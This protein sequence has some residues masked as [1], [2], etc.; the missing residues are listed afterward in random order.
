LSF[1]IRSKDLLARTG[2]LETKSGVF[3]TPHMFP[4]VDPNR[5]HLTRAVLKGVDAGA[6]MTNAYLLRR[7]QTRPVKIELHDYLGFD[8]T[9]ATDSGAYQ[10]LEFGE[11]AVTPKEI[12]RYQEE[13]NS[14]IAVILDVPTGFRTS[15][16]RAR[17][18]VDETIR[19]ADEA[20]A[21][22]TRKDILWVGPIQGGVHL[23][24]VERSATEMGK[25]D[26]AIY[27]LGSPTELMETQHFDILVDMI[28]AAKKSLPISKPFHLFGAG[29]PATFPF[30]VALGC[31]LFD[32]AAYALYAKQDKYFTPEGTLKLEEMEELPCNCTTCRENT[33]NSIRE[34]PL[35]EKELLIARHNLHVCMSELRK[36]REMIRAGRLWEMLEIR[37]HAHPAFMRCFERISYHADLLEQY[38]PAVKLHGI[39]YYGR[40]TDSRPEIQRYSTKLKSAGEQG[41]RWLVLLPSGWRRP[42]H[43]DPAVDPIVRELREI[44][45]V[46]IVFY[47]LAFGPV[48][49]ELDEAYPIPHTDIYDAG[50]SEEYTRSATKV[51]EYV[52]KM[53]PRHI[54]LVFGTGPLGKQIETK[55]RD[56]K[57]SGRMKIG[58]LKEIIGL[59]AMKSQPRKRLGIHSL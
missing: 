30:F 14:D 3:Q 21:S 26:F 58:T 18:T 56:N 10:I 16:Q 45:K 9:I 7:G 52:K 15:L 29:H 49:L 54:I 51:A 41:A 8:K 24:E 50:A 28:V 22:I 46:S 33:A 35:E 31:D 32:S 25:R 12:I 20:L 40:Q 17:S 43:Q 38:N 27:A 47:S 2:T 11:V 48:P 53:D 13:I 36:I 4:V 23:S 57:L 37:S 1:R 59:V 42:F 19:R 39:F 5:P 44:E 34:L 6:I 55:L